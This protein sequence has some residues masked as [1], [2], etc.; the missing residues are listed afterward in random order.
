MFSEATYEKYCY[1]LVP[2]FEAVARGHVS[3]SDTC[4]TPTLFGHFLYSCPTLAL[5][6][7]LSY[8]F[9][10]FIVWACQGHSTK[11]YGHSMDT[12]KSSWRC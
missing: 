12:R 3:V 10:T 11:C 5:K 1:T 8:F 7:T 4:W 9:S 2:K 6:F